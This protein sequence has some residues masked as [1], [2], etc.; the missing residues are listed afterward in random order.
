MSLSGALTGRQKKLSP[1]RK[2]ERLLLDADVNARLVPYLRSLGFD[3]LFAPQ[4]DVNIHDDTEIVKWA[5]MRR[6]YFVCH[7]RFKDGQTRVKLYFEVYKNGGRIIR[8]GGAPQ[9]DLLS[10]LGKILVQRRHWL[11]FFKEHSDGMVVVHEQGMREFT[12]DDLYRRIEGVIT[13]PTSALERPRKPRPRQRRLFKVPKEQ[14]G[15]GL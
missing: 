6:R 9:Q 4:V 14:L 7:D 1:T 5:R 15:P 13:D 11:E 3:V 8:I 2:L 10:S 12:R